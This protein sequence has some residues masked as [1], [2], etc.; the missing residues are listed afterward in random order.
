MAKNHFDATPDKFPYLGQDRVFHCWCESS[1]NRRGIVFRKVANLQR[2]L[3]GDAIYI[4]ACISLY[5]SV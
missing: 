3:T 1:L 5:V 4:E 2:H